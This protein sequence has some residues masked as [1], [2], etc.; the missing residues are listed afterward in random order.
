MK[1]SR[2]QADAIVTNAMDDANLEIER[3]TSI[4]A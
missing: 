4:E 1:Q 2:S 3:I